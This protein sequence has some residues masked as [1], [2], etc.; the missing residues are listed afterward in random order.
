MTHHDTALC[1]RLAHATA[2]LVLF[3]LPAATASAQPAAPPGA[4]ARHTH[5]GRAP[6]RGAAAPAARPATVDATHIL[7]VVNGDVI[8]NTDVENR[9]RLFA[10]SAGLTLSQDVLERLQ[11]QIV[12]QLIDERLRM[13]A[14]EKEKI[15]VPDA[16]IAAAIKEIEARNNL[17][18]GSLTQ[19]LAA[20]GVSPLTLID[21]IRTQIGWTQL[22]RK[23]LGDQANIT[24]AE[25][26][27]RQRLQATQIG[28]QEYRVG[29]IFIPVD[30][31]AARA[32]AERFAET[33]I[34]DLRKGAPFGLVAAQFSQEETALTGGE[35]GWV[36]PNQLDPAVASLIERMPVGAVSNPVA[37]PGGYEIVTLQDRRQIGNQIA[38]VLNM[39]VAFVPFTTPLNPQAPTAQQRDALIKARG[40]SAGVRSCDQMEQVGKA[41]PSSHPVNPGDVPLDQVNPPIFRQLLATQPLNRP[42]QPLVGN[43]GISIVIVC[44]RDQKNLAAATSDEVKAQLLN[45]RVELMSEQLMHD[46][47]RRA[48]I[49]LRIS[50]RA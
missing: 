18:P 31:P 27:E 3:A 45:Q 43:D 6:R 29:E 17:P 15:V 14:V 13:Q 19:K 7:A 21:Q 1:R 24:P 28:T 36:Q 11:H 23:A 49:E 44:S 50:N 39:R 2:L 33:V 10:M 46:L 35:R 12:Q 16:E 4:A 41:N 38:T 37:V 48:T 25:I 30:D 5:T 40:I 26:A 34:N 32:D 9:A 20:A 42:T 8:T 22:L 47:R